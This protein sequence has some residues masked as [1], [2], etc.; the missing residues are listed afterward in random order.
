MQHEVIDHP[1]YESL[2]RHRL[3]HHTKHTEKAKL[4]AIT[5]ATIPYID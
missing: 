1:E 4:L 2:N 5:T 3:L